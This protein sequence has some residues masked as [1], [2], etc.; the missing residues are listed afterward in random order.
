MLKVALVGCGKIADDH[1][2]QIQRLSDVQV[3]AVCDRE[4]LMAE[5]FAERFHVDRAFT[6]LDQ[7]LDQAGPDVVHIT[8]PPQSHFPLATKCL[9]RGIATYVEKPFTVTAEEAACLID[10]AKRHNVALT[11]GHDLQFSHAARRLRAAVQRG[12]L[13]ERP[14][15][16]ES[17][18]C[19]D[20][21]DAKYAR[22]LLGD[23][24]HWIRKLPGGLLHN[25]ISHGVA[26][27]A[28]YL[29]DD[30]IVLA[31]GFQSEVLRSMGETTIVDELRVIL[32]DNRGTTAYFTFSSQMKPLL[33]QFRIFGSRSGFILDEDEQSLIRLRG[34]RFKSYAEKFLPP[35]L[36]AKQQLS[37]LRYNLG[38]FFAADFHMKS[39]MKCLIE[40]FYQAVREGREGPIP[41]RE[42]LLTSRIMDEIFRQ[43]RGND[44]REA[45]SL[46]PR[47][48]EPAYQN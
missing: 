31:H 32:R 47:W 9:E 13:G 44:Q 4:L 25:V 29:G 36:L 22:A 46:V 19:Y 16:L 12:E 5:Q 17:Y 48:A 15:H 24:N 41:T 23:R 37:N 30:P 26:R 1:A 10:T 11:V 38:R 3:V 40:S 39:G 43:L 28:E 2:A 21:G 35:V 33:N 7:L 20:L 18:Y 14:V 27:I 6:D 45:V 34:D 8:T 42:I